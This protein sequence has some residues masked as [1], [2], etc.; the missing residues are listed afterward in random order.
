MTSLSSLSHRRVAV[1][2][3]VVAAGW[4]A[5]AGLRAQAPQGRGQQAPAAQAGP[6]APEKYKNIQ[7]LTDV[8]A[9][10]LL[11]TMDYIVQAT[12][13]QCQGCHVQDDTTKEFAYDKDDNRTKLTARK[14]MQLV[15]TVNA[16]D[17]GARIQCGTC[18]AG[19]NQPAGL[20]LAQPLTDEQIAAMAAAL[21]A[22]QGGAPGAGAAAAGGARGQQGPPAPAVDDVIAK[23]VDAIGGQAALGK[24]QSRVVTGTA[25]NRQRQSSPFTIEEKGAK[26]RQSS[27]D[28][29]VVVVVDGANSW[30]SNGTRTS[31]L[32]S[33]ALWNAMRSA[34]LA[35]PLQLKDRYQLQAGRPRALAGTQTTVNILQGPPMM[36]GAPVPNVTE[37]FSFDATSGLLVRRVMAVR[38]PMGTMQLQTDYANY[39]DVG[40]VKMPFE[41]RQTTPQAITTMTVADV[42][43]NASIDDARFTRP[44]GQ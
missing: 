12:G 35:L 25:V 14:M 10:Q 13:I 42:K 19:R 40:G 3:A 16:G 36:N 4:I 31:D 26:F 23:Y 28:P 21:A 41:I 20:Q 44:K 37:T 18:H 11:P 34:D 39:R 32:T 22:R 6:L 38:T 43:P 24:L 1:A 9:D 33:V 2:I 29:A 17:F 15:K 7:V 30:T 8:Q 27:G 5:A